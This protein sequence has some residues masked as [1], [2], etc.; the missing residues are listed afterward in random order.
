MS[1]LTYQIPPEKL[2]YEIWISKAVDQFPQ[3]GN[4]H[5]NGN[6]IADALS[7]SSVCLHNLNSKLGEMLSV[8]WLETCLLRIQNIRID[9]GST[10]YASCKVPGVWERD[11]LDMRRRTSDTCSHVYLQRHRRLLLKQSRI[12]HS[13]TLQMRSVPSQ[14]II[15]LC[16][17]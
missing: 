17:R 7:T 4:N 2:E 16:Y 13:H 9:G 1:F 8:R 15:V 11:S 10:P 12:P 6:Y 3:G 14:S 5:G